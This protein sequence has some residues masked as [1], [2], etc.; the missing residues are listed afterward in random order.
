MS[1][2][3]QGLASGLDTS[4]IISKLMDVERV[5]YKNMETKKSQLQNQQAVFRQLNT[6]L[7]TMQL[8]AA[9]L[10]YTTTYTKNTA[11]LS[12]SKIASA[13]ANEAAI[14]GSYE[15]QVLELAKN[16]SVTLE[17]VK[18]SVKKDAEGS[19]QDYEFVFKDGASIKVSDL[20]EF[21]NNKK[22]LEAVV[23]K[24]NKDPATYGGRAN[25]VDLDGKGTYALSLTS[26]NGV[27]PVMQVNGIQAGA[28]APSVKTYA[29][30]Q[31]KLKI[32]GIEVTRS[33]NEVKD[34][35]DG[36]T[37]NITAKGTTTLTVGRDSSAVADTVD[38]FV[39]AYN[40]LMELINTN[41]AKPTNEDTVNPLQGDSVL[42]T[43]KD[44][45]Y[46]LFTQVIPA[47]A[48]KDGTGKAG[49][50]EQIGLSID[51]NVTSSSQ[52]TGKIT[53]DKSEFTKALDNN[54][55][56]V[57]NMMINRADE[58]W[59]TMNSS[60]AGQTKGIIASK[61]AGYDSQ[62]KSVDERLEALERSLTYKEERLKTQFNAMEVMMSS[63]SST[64]N[65]LTSQINSL[66]AS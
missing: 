66:S 5:P 52:R 38:K 28:D 33:T 25:L 10:R 15:I 60:Y 37:L 17:G 30:Q 8:A 40:D 49:A 47:S 44:E 32:N 65:W 48:I 57:M 46:N 55:D 13:S 56:K 22:A 18:G 12:D 24:I 4:E 62:I 29:G 16:G 6:K 20:G 51:K 23:A 3:L 39:N 11:S 43:L 1:F 7:S 26:T 41:L 50:L 21:E 61:I 54:F 58:I 42:K 9:E 19:I 59:E 63:L 14:K 34:A 53:F 31:A 27:D 45:L 36:V 2:S 35:I 64:Q